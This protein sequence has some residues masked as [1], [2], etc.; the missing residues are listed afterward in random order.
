MLRKNSETYLFNQIKIQLIFENI[1]TFQF[2]DLFR[3]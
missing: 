3:F 2:N 1:N